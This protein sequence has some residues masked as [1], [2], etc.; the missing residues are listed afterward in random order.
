MEHGTFR[1]GVPKGKLPI[2]DTV[3]MK[4]GL[5]YD[6]SFASYLTDYEHF[7][8][9]GAVD[10]LTNPYGYACGKAGIVDKDE[11]QDYFRYGRAVHLA[12]LEPAKFKASYVIEPEF[13][14]MTQDGRPSNQSKEAKTKKAAWYAELPPDAVVLTEK[15]MVMLTEQIDCLMSHPQVSNIFQN[16]KPEVT[17]RFTH[18]RTRLR[19]KIRP[20]YVTEMPNGEY[21]FFDLKTARSA[22]EGLFDS[23]AARLM[24]D[25]KMAFYWDGMTEIMGRA[26]SACALIPVQKTI[27]AVTNVVWMSE[28]DIDDGR[29]RSEYAIDTLIK[30][31]AENKWPRIKSEGRILSRPAWYRDQPLPQFD[32]DT[33]KKEA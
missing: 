2:F 12:V 7:N 26:P 17:G 3:G 24:Y 9:G 6:E 29:K 11:E 16:G 33:A 10:I 30:C 14:G 25:V 32:W 4:N 8:A 13:I 18:P 21:F 28:D 19:C 15:E 20:D 27:P 1:W 22:E 5:F 31:M 23:D